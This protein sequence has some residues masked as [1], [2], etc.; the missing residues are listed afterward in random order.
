MDYVALNENF[1]E[2]VWLKPLNVQW[3]A[4][5]YEC[6]D[7]SIQIPTSSYEKSFAYLYCSER[8]QTGILQ[9]V[10]H[11][12]TIAGKITQI[13]GFFLERIFY[14]Y[15]IHPTYKASNKNICIVAK[16][17]IQTYCT[18][19]NI[20]FGDFTG[21]GSNVD[22]QETG[23]ML[24]EALYTLLATQNL[25]YQ[26]IYNFE[27]NTITC[28]F[29]KGVDRT[30]SQTV[31]NT[32]TFSETLKNLTDPEY[33]TDSSNYKNYAIVGGEGESDARI[34]VIVDIR[35]PGE[36]MRQ[37]FVD[38]KD[39][40]Q[41]DLT[42]TGYEAQLAQR[43]VEKLFNYLN[44]ENVSFDLDTYK[45]IYLEDFDVGDKVDIVIEDYGLSYEANI[46]EVREVLKDNQNSVEVVVGDKIPTK[47]DK[48]MKG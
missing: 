30:Q 32:V 11:E 37:L 27:E 44:I 1:N 38:A 7:F 12:S 10:H 47:F 29:V 4:K 33:T 15:V 35:K 20:V 13:S 26:L 28:N 24:G 34:Y 2:P 8:K 3:N 9:K 48:I 23:K 42:L 17:L 25:S 5:F 43:G 31:N 14:N 39:L 22:Y 46:I 41:G 40:R 6:G 18:E 16:E 19:Y 36:K 45:I 21:I